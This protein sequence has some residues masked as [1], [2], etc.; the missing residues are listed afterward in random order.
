MIRSFQLADLDQVVSLENVAFAESAYGR[1]DF[2]YLLW[3][4]RDGFLVA[5]KEEKLVGYVIATGEGRE[6]L[7]QSIAVSP[8][9]RRKGIADSL[10]RSAIGYLAK[11][12]EIYLLVDSNNTAAISLY[13]KFSFRETG[14]IRRGYYRNGADAI[15]MARANR[16]G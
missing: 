8:E 10:M 9:F 6:G 1:F 12:E 3:R 15:E 4:A 5:K 14:R 2:M 7:I 11:F 13:H 16:D